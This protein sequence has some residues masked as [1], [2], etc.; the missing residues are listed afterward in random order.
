MCT[1]NGS[2]SFGASMNTEIF[3]HASTI[4]GKNNN[5]PPLPS[6]KWSTSSIPGL[7]SVDESIESI[8][9]TESIE[10]IESIESDSVQA[11]VTEQN[12]ENIE[13]NLGGRERCSREN[14]LTDI[15]EDH[16]VDAE[17]A[18]PPACR[19]NRPRHNSI[20]GIVKNLGRE[21]RGSTGL[22]DKRGRRKSWHSKFT[23]LPKD[24]L[25]KTER[26]RRQGVIGAADEAPED[27]GSAPLSPVGYD[28]HKR[29]SWWNIFVTDDFSTK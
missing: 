27:G 22:E 25:S 16:D 24:K 2:D 5:N 1:K 11:I 8:E 13:R 14:S 4:S 29:K 20:V 15:K 3:L 10:S 7:V 17:D 26:K 23:H 18:E 21:K 12:V 9:S 6:K 19:Q 28:R